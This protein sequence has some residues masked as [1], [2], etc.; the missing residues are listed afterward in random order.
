MT[1]ESIV[2]VTEAQAKLNQLISRDSFAISRHGKIVGIYLSRD[3]IEALVETMELLSSSKFARALK[4]YESGRTKFH[5]AADLD[6]A[7]SA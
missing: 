5:D 3:R 2:N 1:S 7:M 4:D 6:Q